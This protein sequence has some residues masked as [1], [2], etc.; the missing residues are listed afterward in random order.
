MFD[1]RRQWHD[2]FSRSVEHCAIN[3]FLHQC[4]ELSNIISVAS[5][6][7][8]RSRFCRDQ[9]FLQLFDGFHFGVGDDI[10]PGQKNRQRC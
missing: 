2:E 6:T 7:R 5:L 9:T 3:L 8:R 1:G 4:Q 10:L